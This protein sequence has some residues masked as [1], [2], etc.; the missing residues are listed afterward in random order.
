MKIYE[1][2][3]EVKPAN[4]III[5]RDRMN[6][7]CP[8]EEMILADGWAEYV[9]PT[10]EPQPYALS[11]EEI[12]K[13]IVLEQYNQRT[14]ISDQEA[15]DRILVIYDWSKYIGKILKAGQVCVHDDKVW[16]S[17]Q[18][19][20]VL[21]EYAPS[22][23]TSSLYEIIEIVHTGDKDDPIPYTPPMEIFE[24][25]YY[26]EDEVLYLCIRDSG[27]ALTHALRDL[28]G[29]YVNSA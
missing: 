11:P 12:A 23:E 20:A 29:L 6:I 24:G 4:Q 13:D 2:N 27:V 25:K 26:S 18:E 17:R 10:I 21:E 19:H 22:L 7:F 28:S 15:L 16:R 5:R 9:P 8:S 3:G 1:K 14:D